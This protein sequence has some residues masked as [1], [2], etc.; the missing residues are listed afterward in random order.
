MTLV[1]LVTISVC[2]DLVLN[3]Q[4]L[5]ERLKFWLKLFERRMPFREHLAAPKPE[6]AAEIILFGLGR[7]GGRL[8]RRLHEQGVAT[9]G[10]DFDPEAARLARRHG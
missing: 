5:Y 9:L 2:T 6:A 4:A 1:G 8:I 7:Y 10:V 3:G